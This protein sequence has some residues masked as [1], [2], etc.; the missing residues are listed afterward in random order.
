M[1]D[2]ERSPLGLALVPDP[3]APHPKAKTA[4]ELLGLPS[5]A[6]PNARRDA[7]GRILPG[8]SLNPSGA[9]TSLPVLMKRVVDQHGGLEKATE[10]LCEIAWGKLAAGARLADRMRAIEI[11]YDRIHGRAREHVTFDDQGKGASSLQGR[12]L[13]ELIGMRERLR[14]LRGGDGVQEAEVIDDE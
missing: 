8:Q 7:K 6:N 9:R 4:H 3:S 5:P 12:S 14:T 10:V 13:Q 11:L 1:P 2:P